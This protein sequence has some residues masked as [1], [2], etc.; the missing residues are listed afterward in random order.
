MCESADRVIGVVLGLGDTCSLEVVYVDAFGLAAFGGVDELEGSWA[1]DE[2][3]LGAVLVAECVTADDDWLLP[4]RNET[5]DAWNDD[6]FAENCA[7]SAITTTHE[8]WTN[9]NCWK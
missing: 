1:R 6:G 8:L 7:T 5:R 3:V 9:G 2:S 4:A